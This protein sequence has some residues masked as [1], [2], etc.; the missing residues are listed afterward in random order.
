[1][2]ADGLLGVEARVKMGTALDVDL[3]YD[4]RFAMATPPARLR[5]DVPTHSP[6]PSYMHKD[7]LA[8]TQTRRHTLTHTYMQASS[9]NDTH[10][11]TRHTYEE[12]D[13]ESRRLR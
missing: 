10:T 4:E 9:H 11:H 2:L 12:T 8:D 5:A 13:A 1:M 6:T 3:L 7:R